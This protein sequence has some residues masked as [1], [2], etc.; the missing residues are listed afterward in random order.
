[1]EWKLKHGNI[2]SVTITNSVKLPQMEHEPTCHHLV[3]NTTNSDLEF[4][5]GNGFRYPEWLRS[6]I[7][8]LV[9]IIS[10]SLVKI[11]R[12][13]CREKCFKLLQNVLSHNAKES[14]KVILD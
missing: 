5:S 1:M 8:L 3:F 12:S 11:D 6:G 2:R 14:G 10:P 9:L 4:Q 13:L 7:G